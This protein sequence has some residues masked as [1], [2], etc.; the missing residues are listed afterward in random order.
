MVSTA[1]WSESPCS[2]HNDRQVANL[3]AVAE[4]PP[5]SPAVGTARREGLQQHVTKMGVGP[6]IAPPHLSGKQ[7]PV[8]VDVG[9]HRFSPPVEA[10]EV[11]EAEA[12]SIAG[13]HRSP[14]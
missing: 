2:T 5:W 9:Q 7:L 14:P 8:A 6:L 11:S 4:A 12:Q 1:S 13:I 10:V 3:T